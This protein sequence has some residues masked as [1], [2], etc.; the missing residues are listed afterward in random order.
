VLWKG[1]RAIGVRYQTPDD[2]EEEVRAR[3]VID[4]TGRDGLLARH[5]NLREIDRFYPDFSVYGYFRDCQRPDGEES[6]NL[7]VEAVPWGWLWFIPL[8]TGEVSVGLVCDRTTRSVLRERGM[9]AYLRE[10]IVQ[11]QLVQERLA[12]ARLVRGP[13]GTASYGYRSTRYAGP[14]WL[15]VGDAAAFLDPMWAL[16]VAN[17]FQTGKLAGAMAEALVRGRVDEHVVNAEYDHQVRR[18]IAWYHDSIKLV[19]RGNRVHAD[20]PFWQERHRYLAGTPVPLDSLRW[21]TVNRAAAYFLRAI[22]RLELPEDVR[23]LFASTGEPVESEAGADRRGPEPHEWIP[24]FPPQVTMRP[25]AVVR[26]RDS[27]LGPEVVVPGLA[28]TNRWDEVQISDPL[29]I[30][31]LQQVDG[32]RTLREILDTVTGPVDQQFAVYA[33][34]TSAF[35]LARRQGILLAG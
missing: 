28:L 29:L 34:L 2:R 17:A 31:A 19:Y 22:H 14:G 4:A 12:P 10:A 1:E 21:L 25:A 18:V 32:R 9:A 35:S 33:R 7:V 30:Q 26:A 11:S 24:A 13:V 5:M 23:D 20:G 6:G 3:L 27:S 8:H 16:G 15:L